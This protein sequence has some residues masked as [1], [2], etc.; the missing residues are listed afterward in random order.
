MTCEKVLVYMT[1]YDRGL[2]DTKMTHHVDYPFDIGD[3]KEEKTNLEIYQFLNTR[4]ALAINRRASR[5]DAAGPVGPQWVNN[6]TGN[7]QQLGLDGR[8]SQIGMGCLF[9]MFMG[10]PS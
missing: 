7:M 1:E 2:F 5:K 6:A 9:G 4:F 3:C 8:G 10:P